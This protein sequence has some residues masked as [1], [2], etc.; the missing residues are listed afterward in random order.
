MIDNKTFKLDTTE[1]DTS[2]SQSKLDKMRTMESKKRKKLVRVNIRK[3]YVMTTNPNKWKV[4]LST[5]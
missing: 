5:K 1:H 4:Y 3:G 2:L